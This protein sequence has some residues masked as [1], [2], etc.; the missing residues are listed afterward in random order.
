MNHSEII[1]IRLKNQQL[2]NSRY[3]KPEDLVSW[4]GGIQGQDY[5]GAKWAIGLRLPKSTDPDI[6]QSI[7]EKNILRTWLMRGTLHL[8]AT[9]DIRWML[10][11]LAPRIIKSNRRRYRELELNEEILERSNQV[12]KDAIEGKE[13]DRIELLSILRENGISTQGQRAAYMLQRASLDG[14]ICQCGMQSNNPLYI[15]LDN[16]PNKKSLDH[17]EAL[18]ELARRFF[19]SRGPATVGD[20]MWWSGLLAAD[21]RTGLYAIKSELTSESISGQT[22]WYLKDD[23]VE[24]VLPVVHLLPTYDEYLFGYR[25]RSAQI[26]SL[27]KIK[28]KNRYLPTIALNGLIIGTWKRIFRGDKVIIEH[29]LFKKLNKN[30]NQALNRAKSRY[31]K[32]L[33]MNIKF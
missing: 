13:L 18:A 7:N 32:F 2:I 33:D 24:N 3:N 9:E 5:P 6:E 11:L 19:K 27:S 8:V 20:F 14:I 4:L 12:L 16:L 30:E 28:L 23:I 21:A 25:D 1:L 31:G 29:E 26:K 22:Y 15:S 10:G 17:D